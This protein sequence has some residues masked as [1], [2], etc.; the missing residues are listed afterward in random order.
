MRGFK[1]SKETRNIEARATK[2][3]NRRTT[4]GVQKKSGPSVIYWQRNRGTDKGF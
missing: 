3:G 4:Q 2:E 1:E